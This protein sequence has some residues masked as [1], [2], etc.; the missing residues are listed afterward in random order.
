M[1]YSFQTPPDFAETGRAVELDNAV[2]GYLTED[3]NDGETVFVW[4][5]DPFYYFDGFSMSKRLVNVITKRAARVYVLSTNEDSMFEYT[6][7]IFLS[8]S[9]KLIPPDHDVFNVVRPEKQIVVPIADGTEYRLPEDIE[10][11][12]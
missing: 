5:Q 12:R 9:A 2:K 11:M 8:D 6:I 7:D 10:W 3:Q 1:S 4:S